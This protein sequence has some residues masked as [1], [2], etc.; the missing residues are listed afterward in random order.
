V[1]RV[2]RAIRIE[3]PAAT[4]W[5]VLGDF[6]LRELTGGICSRVTTEGRGPGAVRTMHLEAHLGGGCVKERLESLDEEERHM[7]Y[8]LIDSGP[9]PFADYLGSIRVTPA[10]PDACVA[11]MTSAFVPV[12]IDA[13]VARQLSVSNIERALEN[14]RAASLRHA[15]R[16]TP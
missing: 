15:A 11:V 14:A 9:V 7:T 3:A 1:I 10:G 5:R 12:E 2:E 8:R 6:S 13:E 16:S 4:V